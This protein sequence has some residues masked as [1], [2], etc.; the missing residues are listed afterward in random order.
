MERLCFTVNR[1]RR[2][3]S[4]WALSV[5]LLLLSRV[6]FH[7]QPQMH[8]ELGLC[9]GLAVVASEFTAEQET[10]FWIGGAEGG[11]V[12]ISEKLEE[13]EFPSKNCFIWSCAPDLTRRERGRLKHQIPEAT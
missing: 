4:A 11:G 10:R 2:A 8:K 3:L 9:Q 12:V 7:L 13:Y 5:K 6:L 1:E